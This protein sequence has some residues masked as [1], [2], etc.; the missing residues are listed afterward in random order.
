MDGS[1][2]HQIFLLDVLDHAR[3]PERLMEELRFA[4]RRRRPEVVIATANVGFFITRL[5]LLC[6]QFNYGRRGILDR[7]H[8]RLFTFGSLRKML[9]QTGYRIIE[10]R[11][12]PA[13]FSLALGDGRLSRLLLR[14]NEALIHLSKGLFGYQICLRAQ[15]LPSVHHLLEQTV[16]S[17]DALRDE[18]AMAAHE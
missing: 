4:A 7:T 2:Y 18:C 16:E 9:E 1:H 5:M 12:V 13:P 14:A 8:R 6:G 10:T 17:S 11:A 3:D 15:A